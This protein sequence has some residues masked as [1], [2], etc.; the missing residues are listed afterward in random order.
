ISFSELADTK[1]VFEYVEDRDLS[2]LW[3]AVDS[4]LEAAEDREFIAI[5]EPLGF[6]AYPIWHDD[7]FILQSR[8]E[9]KGFLGGGTVSESY[10]SPDYEVGEDDILHAQFLKTLNFL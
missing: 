8:E 1:T 3:L 5:F 7:D 6:P 9:Q 2:L 4:G 10:S